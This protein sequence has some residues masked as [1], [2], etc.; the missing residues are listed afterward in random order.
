ML[1]VHVRESF[2]CRLSGAGDGSLRSLPAFIPNSMPDEPSVPPE[3]APKKR[4][5]RRATS[6][7]LS[8]EP[9]RQSAVEEIK[10]ESP[11]HRRVRPFTDKILLILM[12]VT[13]TS[14]AARKDSRTRG[15]T[16]RCHSRLPCCS[17]FPPF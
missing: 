11:K 16:F 5:S 6:R 10:T 9:P 8:V 7:Q 17:E 3:Q 13:G 12:I 4:L 1:L 2:T 15:E 14:I